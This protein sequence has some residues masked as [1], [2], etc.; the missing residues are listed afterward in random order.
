MSVTGFFLKTRA[1]RLKEGDIKPLYIPGQ[2]GDNECCSVPSPL[3]RRWVGPLTLPLRRLLRDIR[4]LKIMILFCGLTAGW[5]SDGFP[6]ELVS[7]VRGVLHSSKNPRAHARGYPMV[8][9]DAN[10]VLLGS[11]FVEEA[12][13]R[14]AYAAASPTALRYSSVEDYAPVLRAHCRL[15]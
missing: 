9:R 11:F 12:L 13:G 1:L 10:E 2:Q 8:Q 6:W 15:G 4:R 5:G 14:A 7:R 3:K